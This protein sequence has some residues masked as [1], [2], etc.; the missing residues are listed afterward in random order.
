MPVKGQIIANPVSGDSCE[1]LE[2]AGDTMGSG[3]S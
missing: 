3:S 1:C 2:T